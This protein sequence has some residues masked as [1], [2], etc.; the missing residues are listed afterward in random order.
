ML[1]FLQDA[2]VQEC[3]II[4]PPPNNQVLSSKAHLP[5]TMATDASQ[6]IPGEY[7]IVFKDQGKEIGTAR[8]ARQATQTTQLMLSEYAIGQDS[9]LSEYQ[10][11]LKGF[12]AKLS[13]GQLKKLKKDPRVDH[14]SP[15]KLFFLNISKTPT[16]SPVT[17]NEHSAGSNALSNQITP[18]GISRVNGPLNGTGKTAWVIDTGIDL[19]HPDLNVDTQNSISY[20][21]GQSANDIIGHGTH[22]AGII[23]AKNNSRGAVGVA[24]GATVVAVKVCKYSSTYGRTICPEN[25]IIDG[26]DYVTNHANSD[27]VVNMSIGGPGDPDLDNAVTNAAQSYIGLSF[28]ISAGNDGADASNYSPARVNVAN[29]RTISAYDNNDHWAPFSNYGNPPIEYGGPGDNI[30]SLAIG[31]GTTYLSG[32]SM[33]TPHIAGLFL[34][35]PSQNTTDGVVSGDPDG[36]P[37]P[38]LVHDTNLGVNVSGPGSLVSGEQGTWTANVYNSGG[39]ISYQWYTQDVGSNTWVPNGTNQTMS[40]TFSNSGF[41]APAEIKVEV[42]SAGETV[43]KSGKVYIEPKCH[44]VRGC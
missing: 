42:T 33:A 44:P 39:S 25:S 9:L 20:I 1:L 41:T 23:A 12:A 7:I 40:A 21:S 8:A 16:V 2:K 17:I 43:S 14:I 18:W 6:V 19:D 10:Y 30:P 36:S 38:I 27:D 26:V 37:D 35:N 5:S 11:A 31:G 34:A 28:F 4:R 13:P 22:V 24:A 15:N 29:V 32:T 3:K